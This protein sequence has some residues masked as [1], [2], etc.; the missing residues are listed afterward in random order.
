MT[1]PSPSK[2]AEDYQDL[3]RRPGYLI[4]RLHQVHVQLFHE[5]CG[6]LGVTPVQY[7]LL[8]ALAHRPGADQAALGQSIGIDRTTTAQVLARLTAR[9]LVERFPSPTDRRRRLARVTGDGLALLRRMD[10]SAQRAHDRTLAGLPASD[11]GRFL[12]DLIRLVSFHAPTGEP[13]AS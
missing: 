7:S 5:E 2:E 8:T 13:D 9:R 11:R 3:A 1:G 10:P 4:R 6:A 12:A